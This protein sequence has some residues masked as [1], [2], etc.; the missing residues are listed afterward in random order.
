MIRLLVV[1]AAFLLACGAAEAA[2]QDLAVVNQAQF[3]SDTARVSA[4]PF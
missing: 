1:A 3:S 2:K 4:Q